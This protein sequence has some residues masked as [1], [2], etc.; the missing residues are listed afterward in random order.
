[1]IG[2]A[3]PPGWKKPAASDSESEEEG[4]APGPIGPS[5]PKGAIGPSLPPPSAGSD[6]KPSVVGPALPPHL[7]KASSARGKVGGNDGDDGDDSSDSSSVVGPLPPADLGAGGRGGDSDSDDPFAGRKVFDPTAEREALAEKLREAARAAQAK[8]RDA[9][10]SELPQLKAPVGT[11]ARSFRTSEIAETDASWLAAPGSKN[12]GAVG[13]AKGK[14]G[15]GVE[16]GAGRPSERDAEQA[17][18]YD[19]LQ[20]SSNKRQKSLAEMVA[21]DPTL[22]KRR[23]LAPSVVQEGAASAPEDRERGFGQTREMDPR[24]KKAYLDKLQTGSRFTTSRNFL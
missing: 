24:E 7:L 17:R 16:P 4:P 15:P 18:L 10:M 13:A 23:T 1:M 12:A 11:D 9:W 20:Q 5:L 21:E 22:A 14:A 3:F 2:P 6:S 19:A 8:T